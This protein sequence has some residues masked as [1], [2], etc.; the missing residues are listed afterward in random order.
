[1]GGWVGRWVG[2][3]VGLNMEVL[4]AFQTDIIANTTE[5]IT[6]SVNNIETF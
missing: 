1:M 4:Q 5:P 2:R 3:S 6:F